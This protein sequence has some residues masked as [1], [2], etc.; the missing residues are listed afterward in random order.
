M[1]VLKTVQF[2]TTEAG[3]LRLADAIL[4]GV[5][6]GTWKFVTKQELK[7]G[8]KNISPEIF[9]AQKEVNVDYSMYRIPE[10]EIV[11]RMP[12]P[13]SQGSFTDLLAHV[14]LKDPVFPWY[15]TKS[16]GE[17]VPQAALL[18]F[19]ENELVQT[20]GSTPIQSTVGKTLEKKAGTLTPDFSPN[21][22]E[23]NQEVCSVLKVD[24][25]LFDKT[26]P[27]RS[28]L[29]LLTHCRQV[30]IGD[31]AEM[32]LDP[33]GMFS[34]IVC[35]RLPKFHNGENNRYHMYLVSLQGYENMLVGNAAAS[36]CC[37]M[38]LIVLDH[39]SFELTGDAP[40][41]FRQFAANLPKEDVSGGLLRLSACSD[42]RLLDG[43][44]PLLYH[45]RTGDEGMCWYRSPLTP[46]IVPL[47]KRSTPFY[48]GD[49][50]LIYDGSEGIF[51]TS[52]A[53]A[54]E[55]GRIAAL[56]DQVFAGNVMDLRRKG[57]IFLDDME[58]G[59]EEQKLFPKLQADPGEKTL[60]FMS[61]NKVLLQEALQ[62]EIRPLAKWLA[63]LNLLYQIPFQYLI[64]HPG[65]LPDESL[66]FFYLD[67]N[68][69]EA[70]TDGAV[71]VGMDSTRQQ[72]FNKILRT[73]LLEQTSEEVR[74]YRAG[75]Y[76]QDV[77]PS[78]QEVM[79]GFLIRSRLVSSWPT[80]AVRGEDRQG[81]SL[82][83]L[84]MQILAAGYL[85][86]IFDGVAD[87]ITCEEP[88]ESIQMKIEP[89]FNAFRLGTRVMQIDPTQIR[90]S[91]EFARK[92][93]TL[94]DQVVFGGGRTI[95]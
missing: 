53:S 15:S 47:R 6:P 85:L 64:P 89:E 17:N 51:D 9:S 69:T 35:N 46:V 90:R 8:D 74:R 2:N 78:R 82:A 29:P 68:W 23:T 20:G 79:S 7:Q 14:V 87:L 58:A 41:S 28:E 71:S 24:T 49:M 67:E 13:D 5:M 27:R 22:L 86:V 18:M 19:E 10:D 93:L 73:I 36:G 4:P 11:N 88:L 42:S 12:L 62:E 25:K 70:M 31:K 34:V 52:L 60:R 75:L 72:E 44:V 77:P 56:Q 50:A 30:Y 55:S 1:D 43:Y 61:Q 94:G 81:R 91:S 45:T 39:W 76:G 95:E 65:L 59:T 54:W 21:V 57:Q 80:L 83:I 66:R 48:T 84:R 40:M 33:S 16:G 37:V 38:E 3:T 26:A 32:S 92:F 63:E